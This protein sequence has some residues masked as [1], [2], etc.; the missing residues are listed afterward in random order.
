MP[1]DADGRID[2]AGLCAVLEDLRSSGELGRVKAV[3]FVSYFSNPSARSLDETEK[4]AI[5]ET[6]T[7]AGVIVPVV[8]DA[9]YRE[10][11][12]V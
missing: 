10:L 12:G 6:L 3:Y 1:V 8:E 9:A 2:S 4:N 7:K 5:A 11:Y